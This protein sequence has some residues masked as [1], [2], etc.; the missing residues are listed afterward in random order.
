MFDWNLHDQGETTYLTASPEQKNTHKYTPGKHDNGGKP[1][2][3]KK[4]G[5][6]QTGQLH[7]V[8]NVT[9]IPLMNENNKEICMTHG[10][11]LG[12]I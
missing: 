4:S 1:S 10:V 9:D 12:R 11:T 8:Y 3:D 7:N 2:R 6:L 5:N